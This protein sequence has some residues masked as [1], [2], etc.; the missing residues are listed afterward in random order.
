MRHCRTSERARQRVDIPRFKVTPRAGSAKSSVHPTCLVSSRLSSCPGFGIKHN[1]GRDASI[2]SCLGPPDVRQRDQ[3]RRPICR[4]LT[5][6]SGG[7]RHTRGQCALAGGLHSIVRARRAGPRAGRSRAL[8]CRGT[9][10]AGS[11]RRERS[12]ATRCYG[13]RTSITS[14]GSGRHRVAESLVH[15]YSC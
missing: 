9:R 4:A 11:T 14:G 5:D 10:D 2:A 8:S 1:P 13:R 12:G 6:L 15:R 7:H 3:Q